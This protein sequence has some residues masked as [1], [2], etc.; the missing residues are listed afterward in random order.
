MVT[1]TSVWNRTLHAM[2]KVHW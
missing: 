2:M 1:H